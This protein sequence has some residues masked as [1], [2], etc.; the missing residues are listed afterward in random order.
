MEIKISRSSRRCCASDREFVH[1][2]EIVSLVRYV[3]GALV[4]E[5]YARENWDDSKAKGAYSTWNTRFYDPQV[6]QQEPEEKFSPLRQIFYEATGSESRE[7]LATAFLA[8]Q[9]LRRQKVFR[10]V[11]ESE[12]TEEGG[13]L[14][15]YVDRIG[16]K[17]IEVR[18][19]NFT[20]AELESARFRLMDRL[21][22]LEAPPAESEAAEEVVAERAETEMADDMPAEEQEPLESEEALATVGSAENT[23]VSQADE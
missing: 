7:E 13:K 21:M 4:R 20:F 15:L 23:E 22:A 8:A 16:N 9:L 3:D 17:L 11:R 12:E 1:E 14:I 18:D 10:Q 6:A 2:D 5:D 19:P